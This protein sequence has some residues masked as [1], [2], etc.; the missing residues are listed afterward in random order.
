VHRRIGI[1]LIVMVVLAYPA[2]AWLIGLSAEHTWQK[3]EQTLAG[4]VP[5]I[6]IAK[7]EYHRGFYS[8]TEEVTYR[9]TGSFAKAL[10]AMP[11]G[12]SD[13]QIT[14]RNTIHHGPLPQMQAFAPATIDTQLVLPPPVSE[15]LRAV[16][17]DKASLAVKTR[18]HWFG[19][20]T[21]TLHSPAFEQSMPDGTTLNWRGLEGTNDVGKDLEAYQGN[22]TA[23]GLDVK[24]SQGKLTL[25]NL[26]LTADRQQTA[27]EGVYVGGINVTLAGLEFEQTTPARKIALH[28]VTSTGRSSVQGEYIDMDA[29][30]DAAAL[31][32]PQ[33]SATQVGY[34][35]RGTHLHA[36]SLSNLNKSFMALQAD[37]ANTTPDL[38]KMQHVFKTDGVEILLHDP[39]FEM[40]RIGFAMAEGELLISIKTVL[41]GLTRN[42]MEGSPND[43]R[44][45]L[46]KHLQASA[47]VRIDTAL[48]DKLLNSSGKGD[49]FTAQ[50]QGLQRQGYLK[51]EGKAL[52]THLTYEGGQLKVNG[53]FFPAVGGMPPPPSGG[54]P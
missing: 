51:L 37:S 18:L 6:Q 7:R 38:A 13:F 5:Y 21:T 12:G 29:K 2:A 16:F 15:K 39:V 19:G 4:R 3:R 9:F 24:A 27:F 11:G 40:P 49:R 43:V 31:E 14:V 48:L 23:P 34:E 41:H 8:S 47:D 52:T 17:G 30:I 36:P 46:A 10:Q 20:S 44:G 54:H 53:L 26:H 33:F 45:A 28:K 32:L 1:A 50:L 35:F 42:E 22:L 25:D